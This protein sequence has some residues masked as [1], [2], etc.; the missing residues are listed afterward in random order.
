VFFGNRYVKDGKRA[1]WTKW[2]MRLYDVDHLL[3]NHCEFKGRK[4]EHCIYLNLYGDVTILGSYFHDAY[5]Q[6]IQTVFRATSHHGTLETSA[7]ERVHGAAKLRIFNNLVVNCGHVGYHYTRGIARPGFAFSQHKCLD[8]MEVYYHGNTLVQKGTGPFTYS[9]GWARSFG[10]IMAQN[11]AYTEG[12]GNVINYRQPSDRPVIQL[13]SNKADLW[14]GNTLVQGG[15]VKF[16]NPN[17]LI[18]RNN[19]G[20]GV[21]MLNKQVLGPVTGTYIF[22]NGERVK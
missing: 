20:P 13:D 21:V 14:E 7:P 9:G 3:V 15:K 2:D 11:K 10:A 5:S 17:D 19:K 22:S 4:P 8:G 6:A 16:F 18:W 1:C 12:V